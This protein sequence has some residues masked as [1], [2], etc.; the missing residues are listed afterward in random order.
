MPSTPRAPCAKR[1][2]TCATCRSCGWSPRRWPMRADAAPLSAAWRSSSPCGRWMR[3]CRPLTGTSPLFSG[4]D[5]LKQA[6]SGH[7]MCTP[8]GDRRAR[9]PQRR[10]WSRATSSSGRCWPAC[11][12]SR[13]TPPAAASARLGWVLAAAA[14][15]MV[16]CW[17]ARAR[18][19]SP[20]RWCWL[21][22]GWRLLGWKK[23]LAV[24][25]VRRD[26]AGGAG[27]DLAAGARAHRTH[28]ARAA[29]RR[30]GRRHRAVRSRAIWGAARAWRA[31]IRSTASARATSARRSR[32][33]IP[34][35]DASAGLGRRARRC[36]RTRSCWKC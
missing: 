16:C 10:A 3:C 32:P 14:V 21:L 8:A 9:S 26:V 24:F 27:P 1:P 11:R 18:R 22:S 23:L 29:A 15:G 30:A 19:G 4:I 31:S 13:C 12:R 34:I 7:G 5:A 17:P 33:A 20:T 28:H 36:T 25:A 2:A 35:P 6:I